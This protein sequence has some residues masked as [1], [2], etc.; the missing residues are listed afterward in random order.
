MNAIVSPWQLCLLLNILYSG[1]SS[2][3]LQFFFSY[4]VQIFNFSDVFLASLSSF[5]P[6]LLCLY[7]LEDL[8]PQP[9][10]CLYHIHFL[11]LSTSFHMAILLTVFTLHVFISISTPPLN[12]HSIYP[13]HSVRPPHCCLLTA[14]LP[15][16]PSHRYCVP[17]PPPIC[18]LKQLHLP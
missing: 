3:H 18:L 6:F 13:S 10:V 11:T 17:L 1:I 2:L 8:P 15:P 9:Y 7:L 4:F 5:T 14:S 16:P 12:H